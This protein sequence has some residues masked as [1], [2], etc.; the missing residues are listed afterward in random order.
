MK[1]ILRL[2]LSLISIWR[3]TIRSSSGS[4]SLTAEERNVVSGK[5][6]GEFCDTLKAAG[7]N[8]KYPGAPQDPFQQ[9]EGYRYLA[10]LTRT[11]LDA[12]LE[13]GDVA[14]PVLNR[15][16]HETA[17]L[18]ADNP[19]NFYQNAK[20]SGAYDYLLTGKRNSVFYLGFFTQKGGYGSS[21]SLESTG[22]LEDGD[23]TCAEDGTIEIWLSKTRP[24]QGNWLPL[25]E[26]SNLLIVRQTFLDKDIE[27]PAELTISCINPGKEKQPFSPI[28][29]VNGLEQAS[30][31]VAGAPLLFA[32]W[33]RGFKKQANILPLFD[34]EINRK[35]G[36]V[37][38]ITY[39][40]SYWNL[41]KDE[42]LVIHVTP[43]E[44][45]YWNFQLNNY[46]MES[47]DYR[48]FKIHLN[49]SSAW[50]N[51]DGSVDIIVAH[52]DPGHPNWINTCQ[53]QEGTMCFRWSKA[54]NPVQPQTQVIPFEEAVRKFRQNS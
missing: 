42:A 32:R 26:E 36:G 28:E 23:Y 43:P 38:S 15:M 47:L 33:A 39:Y 8:L 11:A 31:F 5:V 34:P 3:N 29:L 13:H 30:M 50:Y 52:Q 18:G 14:Y 21:A 27:T 48:Y 49:K 7:A 35:M 37:D 41:R 53:H 25:E 51:P 9:A 1:R 45:P 22:V 17:K 4:N 46:W 40:H 16:V 2:V 6:W 10:R 24:A 12:F 20:I 44:C 54:E 19:D